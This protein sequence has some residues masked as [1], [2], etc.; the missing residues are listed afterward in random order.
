SSSASTERRVIKAVLVV[1]ACLFLILALARPQWGAR[2]ETLSRRGVDV[3]V[4]VDTSLS[5]LAEDVKPNRLAQARA[6]VSSLIDLL[7]GDRVG[8][9]A[10]SGAAYVACPLTLDYSAASL[11]VDVLD[12]D[13][14]PIRGTAIAE[15]IRTS[16]RAFDSSQR[17]YK[18]LIL[19]TDGEDHEGDVE[20]AVGAARD[21]G[22]T[23]FT[24]GIGS[25]SGEPIPLRNARGDVVGYKEDHDRRK[26]T[27]RL[28]ESALESMALRTGGRY[29]RASTEGIELRRI[30]EEIAKMDQR[31]LSARLQTAFEE[32]YQWPLLLALLLL[33]LE[34]AISER[35]RTGAAGPGERREEAA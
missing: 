31:T 30:Y 15:A 33:G 10:F 32:R 20:T 11:F 8:L 18:V 22:V 23:I 6:A 28:G 3:I 7:Q 24:V 1:A 12:T 4:A 19:I 2:L 9:V 35:T 27:S 25:P 26:V 29:F 14:I 5:M 21:E 16:T 34:A 13:L 17:R